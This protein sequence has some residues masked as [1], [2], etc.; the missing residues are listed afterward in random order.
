MDLQALGQRLKLGIERN[1]V[2][3]GGDKLVSMIRRQ[4]IGLVLM[5]EDLAKNTAGK[6][7]IAC[8]GAK[9]PYVRLGT[10]D[11]FAAVTGLSGTKVYILKRNCSGLNT[12]LHDLRAEGLLEE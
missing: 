8:E 5:T 7:A 9:V 11:D 2:L 6:I 10:V 4:D 1:Q 12:V 3:Y